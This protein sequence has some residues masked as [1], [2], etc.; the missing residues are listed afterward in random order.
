MDICT[1]FIAFGGCLVVVLKLE[2]IKT[3]LSTPD[4]FVRTDYFKTFVPLFGNGLLTATSDDHRY[5]KKFFSKPFS[6]TQMKYYVPIIN[7]HV[8]VLEKVHLV[9][10]YCYS[11]KKVGLN[12]FHATGVFL[13]PL[14]TSE[15]LAF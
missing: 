13:Y 8:K 4:E 14:K 3:I 10:N 12:S 5:Q 15:K 11:H 2:Y 1:L 6:A 7:K 9:R